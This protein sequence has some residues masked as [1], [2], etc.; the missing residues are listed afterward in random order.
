MPYHSRWPGYL[1]WLTADA[2][3]RRHV[4][5]IVW[6]W[7]RNAPMVVVDNH[8]HV[9]DSQQPEQA[10][11]SSTIESQMAIGTGFCIGALVAFLAIYAI[12][13]K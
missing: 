2:V 13:R 4:E 9:H 7:E 5:D 6:D 12:A 3:H 10:A 1:N 8:S 11:P